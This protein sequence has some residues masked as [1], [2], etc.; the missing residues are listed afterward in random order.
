MMSLSLFFNLIKDGTS[1]LDML[2][3]LD[4]TYYGG[5]VSGQSSN[6]DKCYAMILNMF[7]FKLLI[8][9]L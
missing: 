6:L 2:P 8:K 5:L 1:I 7:F 9:Y 3:T 4:I